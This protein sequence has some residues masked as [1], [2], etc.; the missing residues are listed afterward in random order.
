MSE[1]FRQMA[2]LK[3]N[4]G[5]IRRRIL[6]PMRSLLV[7]AAFVGSLAGC[8]STGS[9]VTRQQEPIAAANDINSALRLA[10]NLRD[11]GELTT[12]I[13]IYQ[14]AANRADGPEILVKLGYTLLQNGATE[15]AGGVFRRALSQAP[16]HPSALL[17]LGTA[18]LQLGE[19]ER[20]IQYL[21]QL[22]EQ[23]NSNDI[24]RYSA[25]GAAL[26][27]AGR[28]D[29]SLSTY[30]A[31]LEIEPGNLDL[32]SNLA[33]S[34]ALS[35]RHE[36]A[37]TTMREVTNSLNAQRAHQ[38][39][40]VLILALAGQN[41]E[42]VSLGFRQLGETETRDVLAQA[43]TARGLTTAADRARAMI[44]GTG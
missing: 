16:D 28:H 41:R 19:I 21:T 38:R 3:N 2:M 15:R 18:Y 33:L 32:K 13:A 43:S 23:G 14:Q 35:D 27:L 9:E 44:G 26:D 42:A 29:Q 40:M 11:R 34:H 1:V 25:L 5:E 36:E 6:V 30:K 20:S 10:D 4:H 22:V 31:G 39:N 12:A 37:I 7:F 24:R 8:S 17:G